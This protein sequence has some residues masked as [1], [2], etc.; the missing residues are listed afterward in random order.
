[1]KLKKILFIEFLKITIN[2]TYTIKTKKKLSF[3]IKANITIFK[4]K[5]LQIQLNENY[6][7]TFKTKMV[8]PFITNSF[9]INCYKF[10]TK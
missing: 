3:V 7:E 2:S 6:Y 5:L 10:P 8:I 9:T 4:T 1:M